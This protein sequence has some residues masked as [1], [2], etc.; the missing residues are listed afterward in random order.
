[1]KKLLTVLLLVV[2]TQAQAETPWARDCV[3]WYG[4][5]IPV[6]ERTK[7]NCP[8]GS[9]HWDTMEDQTPMTTLGSR[10]EYT[11]NTV[12]GANLVPGQSTSP[13]T[14]MSAR[15]YNLPNASYM[16]INIGSTTTVIQTSKTR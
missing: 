9:S 5:K 7:A 15:T 6:T 3:K 12:A 14:G 2:A 8:N 4:G 16:V 13:S 1:M 11:D 10:L